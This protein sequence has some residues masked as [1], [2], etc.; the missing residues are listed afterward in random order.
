LT[1]LVASFV[2]FTEKPSPLP[3]RQWI[4]EDVANFA[5]ISPIALNG[6]DT[7]HKPL[8]GWDNFNFACLRATTS[9]SRVLTDE[10][11]AEHWRRTLLDEASK[12]LGQLG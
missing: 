5:R 6:T 3:G 1:E 4:F 9:R 7:L 10:A 11:H 2:I 8:W 12:I